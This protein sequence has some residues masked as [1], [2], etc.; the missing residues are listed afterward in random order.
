MT[1][2]P[3]PALVDLD[4]LHQPDTVSATDD[5]TDAQV[6]PTERLSYYI[7]RYKHECPHVERWSQP[8]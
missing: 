1:I 4:G 7:P 2:A 5:T 3:S 8:R 6:R